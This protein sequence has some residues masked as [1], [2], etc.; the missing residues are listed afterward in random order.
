MNYTHFILIEN[1][2]IIILYAYIFTLRFIPVAPNTS[3]NL[4]VLYFQHVNSFKTLYS[5]W[6]E[7]KQ[8][9]RCGHFSH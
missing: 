4:N 7:Q 1:T 8:F 9:Q 3:F 2:I 6:P 5:I